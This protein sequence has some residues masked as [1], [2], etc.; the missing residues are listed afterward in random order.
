M[1]HCNTTFRLSELPARDPS[2]WSIISPWGE[3]PNQAFTLS[4]QTHT[5]MSTWAHTNTWTQA[6][7]AQVQTYT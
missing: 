4:T 1:R 5:D 2:D 7:P 6:L 3:Q